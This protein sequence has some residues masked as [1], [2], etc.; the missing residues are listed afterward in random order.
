MHL[1]MHTAMFSAIRPT[2]RS[3][4]SIAPIQNLLKSLKLV[5][6]KTVKGFK[7]SRIAKG[8][9]LLEQKPEYAHKI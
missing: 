4:A 8:L 1:T 3:A 2:T 5:L 6:A 9:K 7:A